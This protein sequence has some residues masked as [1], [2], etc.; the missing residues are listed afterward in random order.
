MQIRKKTI[1]IV[2]STPVLG[3]VVG[4]VYSDEEK[5]KRED[6]S[7]RRMRTK[8]W[9]IDGRARRRR[10]K[11][12]RP[13]ESDDREMKT[14]VWSGVSWVVGCVRWDAGDVHVSD[15]KG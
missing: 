1:E 3:G 11:A 5:M 12:G 15:Q 13:I 14:N 4:G 8:N 9:M 7:E 2:R 6:C 10:G